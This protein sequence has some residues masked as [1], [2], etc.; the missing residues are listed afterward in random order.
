MKPSLKII[1]GGQTGVDRSK[2][3][4]NR[5]HSKRFAPDNAFS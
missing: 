3:A 1:A 2:A 5:A 4:M